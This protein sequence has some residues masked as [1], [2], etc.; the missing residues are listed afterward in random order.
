MST[1][2]ALEKR[3]GS[4]ASRYRQNDDDLEVI[5]ADALAALQAAELRNQ[6]LDDQ[7]RLLK[8]ALNEEDD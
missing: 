6:E 7:V 5:L 3:Y 2:D 4:W 8:W 1:Y